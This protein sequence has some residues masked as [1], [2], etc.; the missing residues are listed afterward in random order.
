MLGQYW[1]CCQRDYQGARRSYARGLQVNP[2]YHF[3]QCGLG[4]VDIFAGDARQGIDLPNKVDATEHYK[5]SGQFVQ[6]VAAGRI[7]KTRTG[8]CLSAA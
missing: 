3:A 8:I 6:A 1:S 5:R 2:F 7:E 4:C